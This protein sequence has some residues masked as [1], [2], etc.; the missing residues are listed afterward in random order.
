MLARDLLVWRISGSGIRASIITAHSA[1]SKTRVGE[2]RGE[3]GGISFLKSASWYVWPDDWSGALAPL[4]SR[5]YAEKV[6]K[7]S[8][9]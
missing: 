2:V 3:A 1:C 5:G 7:P 6:A 9:K 4:I 8:G